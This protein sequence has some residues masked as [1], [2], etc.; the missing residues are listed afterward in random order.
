[1]LGV[2]GDFPNRL[3]A[4]SLMY[5]E[6]AAK[7][8]LNLAPDEDDDDASIGPRF[9]VEYEAMKRKEIKKESKVEE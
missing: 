6:R 7:R 5:W 1:V 3:G 8:P 2:N 9:L 4:R